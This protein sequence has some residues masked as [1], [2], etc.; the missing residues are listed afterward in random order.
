MKWRPKIS[1][2]TML[3]ATLLAGSGGLLYVHWEPWHSG[4]FIPR[5]RVAA[6]SPDCTRIFTPLKKDS[7]GGKFGYTHLA[8]MDSARGEVLSE[9][10]CLILDPKLSSLAPD[11]SRAA[12]LDSGARQMDTGLSA[13]LFIW[14]MKTSSVVRAIGYRYDY[15][16]PQWLAF[17]ADGNM[18]FSQNLD[19]FDARNGELMFGMGRTKRGIS[20]SDDND[21]KPFAAALKEACAAQT[22]SEFAL[23]S[24]PLYVIPVVDPSGRRFITLLPGSEVAQVW[25]LITQKKI[26]D[27]DQMIDPVS[28]DFARVLFFPDGEHLL[29]C[30][31][32]Q[33]QVVN[34]SDGKVVSSFPGLRFFGNIDSNPFNANGSHVLLNGDGWSTHV[35][36]TFPLRQINELPGEACDRDTMRLTPDGMRLV[37]RKWGQKEP[38]RFFDVAQGKCIATVPEIETRWFEMHRFSPDGNRLF[39]EDDRG[40]HTLDRRRPEW[41]WGVPYLPEFWLVAVLL[42]AV[43]GSLARDHRYFKASAGPS[44]NPVNFSFTSVS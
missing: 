7:N 5:A 8:L 2:L 32:E 16:R 17:S 35:H 4:L 18:L 34:L 31:F 13:R 39:W 6:I 21:N 3:L 9:T 19:C 28:S 1:L 43:I 26:R 44:S 42:V 36:S 27:L 11:G 29:R 40:L 33:T 15:D 24:K 12:V 22:L 30:Y 37:V 38:F 25:D 14:D 20:I 10:P 23:V 41:L